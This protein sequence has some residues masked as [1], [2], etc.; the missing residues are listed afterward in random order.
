MMATKKTHNIK[1]IN[2]DKILFTRI[3]ILNKC[4]VTVARF[5][6]LVT[7]N[8]MNVLKGINSDYWKAL[9]LSLITAGGVIKFEEV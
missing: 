8:E 4:F 5:F 1:F 6:S 9:V 2:T 3:K 7:V